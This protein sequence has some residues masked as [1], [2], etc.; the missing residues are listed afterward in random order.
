MVCMGMWFLNQQ[1]GGQ[2]LLGLLSGNQLS[3]GME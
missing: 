1:M 3:S 2:L